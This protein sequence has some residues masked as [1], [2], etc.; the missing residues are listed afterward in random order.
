[1]IR[2]PSATYSIAEISIHS[3]AEPDP[4]H[5]YL[6]DFNEQA[7]PAYISL[8]ESGLIRS[9]NKAYESN[10]YPKGPGESKELEQFDS[11]ANI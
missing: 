7:G 4:D 8:S 2:T 1:V 9:V 5:F 6:V 10:D 3:F 11:E